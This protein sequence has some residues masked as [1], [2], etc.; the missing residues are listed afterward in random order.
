MIDAF[1][2]PTSGLVDLR[3]K[4]LGS[5][6]ECVTASVYLQW[7]RESTS[8]GHPRGNDTDGGK[9]RVMPQYCTA[10]LPLLMSLV[11]ESS[12]H[13]VSFITVETINW[14]RKV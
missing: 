5:Y 3:L 7:V 12:S 1:G 6:D 2:K 4:W 10:S 11:P 8:Y 13:L 9:H 14:D